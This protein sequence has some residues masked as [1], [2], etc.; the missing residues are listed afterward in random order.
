MTHEA[1]SPAVDHA[2]REQQLELPA[3]HEVVDP[4]LVAANIDSGNKPAKISRE[5]KKAPGTSVTDEHPTLATNGSTP[6][7][8][9]DGKRSSAVRRILAR[10]AI[11]IIAFDP[12]YLPASIQKPL[13]AT[14]VVGEEHYAASAMALLTAIGAAAAST[15]NCAV[16]ALGPETGIAIRLCLLTENRDMPVAEGPVFFAVH[17][18]QNALLDQHQIALATAAVS[19][20]IAAERRA[21]YAQAVKAAGVLGHTPPPPLGDAG[22]SC[23]AASPQIVVRDA[24]PSAIT[25]ALAGGTSVLLFDE[26][27]APNF[28]RIGC[29]D[30]ATAALLNAVAIGRPLAVRDAKSGYVASRPATVAV[31]AVQTKDELDRL[32]AAT[33]DELRAVAFVP[34]SPP[35]PGGD[36]A[37]ITELLG[38]VH[39][40]T[41]AAPPTFALSQTA[42]SVIREGAHRWRHQVA[43]GLH[44][45]SA[46]I[47]QLPDLCRRLAVAFHLAEAAHSGD[48]TAEITDIDARR[49][50]A[51]IDHLLLPV[52]VQALGAVS[53]TDQTEADARHLVAKI[54]EETILTLPALEKR[55]LQ[56]GT[57]GTVRGAR[58]R[59]ALRRLEELELV[60]PTDPPN[61][62]RAEYIAGAPAIY[63]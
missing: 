46:Y 61:G 17:R 3:R 28:T 26:R 14:G 47:A 53:T 48:L 34:A 52:A 30:P 38:R 32:P 49:A 18:L 13:E 50:A 58:F 16:P 60:I 25:D 41:A 27:R 12:K 57:Q 8:A 33:A 39:S 43:A 7:R 63:S 56:R 59:A 45:L 51:L 42:L 20:R 9:C 19:Q 2:A 24:G 6:S 55:E 1:A 23:N 62:G 15:T 35:P 29:G 37:G 40:L 4:R 10:A 21:L 11:P 5:T 54:R 22:E 44:P 31:I 36:C